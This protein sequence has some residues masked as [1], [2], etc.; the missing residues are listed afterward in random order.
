M[1][2]SKRPAFVATVNVLAFVFVA[3]VLARIDLAWTCAI[4][5]V[6]DAAFL[7][8]GLYDLFWRNRS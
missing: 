6:V 2:L 8:A 1:K 7:W 5:I 4:L 3:I